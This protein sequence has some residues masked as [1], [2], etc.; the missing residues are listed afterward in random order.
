VITQSWSS[1]ENTAG[2]SPVLAVDALNVSFVTSGRSQHI[3]R[4][5]SVRVRTGETLGIVGESGSGKTTLLSAVLGLLP[6]EGRVTSGSVLF[7]GND[8]LQISA[9]ERRRLR[10]TA[11]RLIPQRAMTSL[12]P[13]AT[14]LKQF[15][16]FARASGREAPSAEELSAMLRRVG[17]AVDPSR[18]KRHPHEFS[19]GQL[20]RMLI[21]ASVLLGEPSI[22]F[23]DEPTSTLDTTVQ[24]QVLDLLRRLQGE[25]G[26]AVVFVSHDLGV[27][28]QLCERVLV[29]YAGEIVEDAAVDSLYHEPRHP[30]TQALLGAL[31]ERHQPRE[32]L[33]AIPG[34]V[35]DSM[36]LDA[37]CRF[38]P[39]CSK[40]WELCHREWPAD[41][42]AFA[43]VVKCHLFPPDPSDV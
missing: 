41:R 13:V 5:V 9:T 42:L 40:A 31:A 32:P 2:A 25:T 33:A 30:Y 15:R 37:G 24:A 35:G 1:A 34:R 3:L 17:L 7:G 27:V 43:S 11:L 21:A 22:I 8:L 38:A 23:A 39:R 28:A 4:D 14:I 12:N 16:L 29:M 18:L 10:G 36:R 20:Q 19:G 6:P 26:V